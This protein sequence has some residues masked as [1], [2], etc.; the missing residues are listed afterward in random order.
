M[1]EN[2]SAKASNAVM[3]LAGVGVDLR[4]DAYIPMEFLR[5]GGKRYKDLVQDFK[6]KG[7]LS[8]LLE[9]EAVKADFNLIQIGRFQCPRTNRSQHQD[10]E[11][12]Q[13]VSASAGCV[14]N[15][16]LLV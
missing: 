11:A 3:T 12:F 9:A 16:H 8:Q 7:R 10:Q 1:S 6:N 2:L 14:S 5:A 15:C 13:R 4:D